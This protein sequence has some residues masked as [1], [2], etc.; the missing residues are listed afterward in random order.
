MIVDDD[1]LVRVNLI[2]MWHGASGIRMI[3]EA[4]DAE[5]LIRFSDMLLR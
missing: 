1:P 3:C 4:R 5:T 2:M